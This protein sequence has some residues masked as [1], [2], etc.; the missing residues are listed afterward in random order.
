ME[1]RAFEM[2]YAFVDS[3]Y[4][5]NYACNLVITLGFWDSDTVKELNRLADNLVKDKTNYPCT[6]NE[7]VLN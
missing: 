7:S 5:P 2:F 1:Q 3:G 6:K 4:E